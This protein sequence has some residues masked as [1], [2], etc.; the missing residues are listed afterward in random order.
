MK[1][2]GSKSRLPPAK[3]TSLSGPSTSR[4]RLPPTAS[5]SPSSPAS[6]SKPA[7]LTLI[8]ALDAASQTNSRPLFP[9]RRKTKANGSI[10]VADLNAFRRAKKEIVEQNVSHYLQ[11]RDDPDPREYAHSGKGKQ[12]ALQ[13]DS[14]MSYPVVTTTQRS[15]FTT[16]EKGKGAGTGNGHTPDTPGQSSPDELD[17]LTQTTQDLLASDTHGISNLTLG[18]PGGSK[19]A[20]PG[21]AADEMLSTNTE[22]MASLSLD[23]RGET[24]ADLF[25]DD[26]DIDPSASSAEFDES[27][28]HSDLLAIYIF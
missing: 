18:T 1:S 11:H 25:N 8:D 7:S 15:A 2:I 28:S 26:M 16:F 12:K 21:T 22:G 23:T 10:S 13:K 3:P 4:P 19:S 6:T 17:L 27:V 9:Y 24:A 20:T 5:L 14:V